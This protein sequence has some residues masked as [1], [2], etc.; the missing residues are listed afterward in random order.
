MKRDLD[1]IS[2]RFFDCEIPQEKLYLLRYFKS[3]MQ[4][5]FLRYMMV[6]EDWDQFREHTGHYCSKRMLYK[7]WTRYQR[8]IQAHEEVKGLLTVDAM[9]LLSR[10]ESG[11]FK[12]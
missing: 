10:I 1:F 3:D 11:K 6:F 8:I 12:C 2:G 9:E 4:K 5:A 7:L